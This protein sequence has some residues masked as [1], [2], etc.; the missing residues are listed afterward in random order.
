VLRKGPDV[1]ATW[2]DTEVARRWLRLCP[3]RKTVDGQPAEATEAE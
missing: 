3:V 2:S 1:V